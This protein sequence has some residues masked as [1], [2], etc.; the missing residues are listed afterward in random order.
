MGLV[1][2]MLLLCLDYVAP[3]LWVSLW[4]ALCGVFLGLNYATACDYFLFYIYACFYDVSMGHYMWFI[5][6]CNEFHSLHSQQND[7]KICIYV[8]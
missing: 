5:V 8:A 7:G 6:S 3:I 1:F 2:R 4:A